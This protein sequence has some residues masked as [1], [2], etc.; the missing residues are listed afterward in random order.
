MGIGGTGFFSEL[1]CEMIA[2]AACE[3]SYRSAARSVSELTGQ[4]ISHTAAWNVIQQLG[5]RVDAQEQEAAALAA[6]GEGKGELDII[7]N[8][9]K[10]RRFCWS[11]DGGNNLARLLC[12]KVTGK[13]VE[14]L[15]GLSTIVLPERYAG[16]IE[17]KMSAAKIPLHE[18]KGFDAFHQMSVPS[19]L[20][21]LK[22][23]VRPRSLC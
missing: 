10:G 9:M 8:R 15:R 4:S 22:D 17:V 21:W 13:L 2:K 14:T 11:I 20:P 16:Q 23:I 1:L 6:K 12:L 7:G 19:A 3:G 5:K 18:G